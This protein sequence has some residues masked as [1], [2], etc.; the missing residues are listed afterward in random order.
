[1]SE[2]KGN[3]LHATWAF[4]FFFGLIFLTVGSAVTFGAIRTFLDEQRL[5]ADHHTVEGRAMFATE[6]RGK[7]GCTTTV[8]V[9]YP[10]GASITRT[11]SQSVSC[12]LITL[13]VGDTLMVEHTRSE[14]RIERVSGTGPGW[15]SNTLLPAVAS[16][17]LAFVGIVTLCRFL[18]ARVRTAIVRRRGR[19]LWAIVLAHEEDP[20][21][22][23][24]GASVWR[25]RAE[26]TDAETGRSYHFVSEPFKGKPS[27]VIGPGRTVEVIV[28]PDDFSRYT[29]DVGVLA[30]PI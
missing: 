6:M 28:D 14:P 22:N 25:I 19:R 3:G 26:W 11:F 5:A 29:M 20:S 17:C 30:D 23:V 27:W 4:G 13:K 16:A 1:M 10:R 9:E 8:I 24:D 18:V 21:I 7:G 15:P 12:D 2:A